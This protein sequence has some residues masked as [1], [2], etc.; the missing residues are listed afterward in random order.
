MNNIDAHGYTLVNNMVGRMKADCKHK[1][2]IHVRQL[3]RRP[4]VAENGSVQAEKEDQDHRDL[5]EI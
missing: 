3:Q 2:G 1:S 5:A 4:N